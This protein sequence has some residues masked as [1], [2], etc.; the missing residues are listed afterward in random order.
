[1]ARSATARAPAKVN[2]A[3]SVGP[4]EP[5]GTPDA[6]MHPI[7]SWMAAIDLFDEVTLTE[8]DRATLD[9]RWAEDAPRPSPLGWLESDD[10]ALRALTLLAQH[11]GRE[12][13]AH[14]QLTK[15]I[16]VG[17]GLG[18]GSSDAAAC[19]T[20]ANTLFGLGLA[21]QDLA[22]LARRLG[23]DIPFFLDEAP[24]PRPALVTH[25]GERIRR[26]ALAP[27]ELV[28]IL[29]GFGCQTGAVYREY[30]ESPLTLDTARV[31]RLA[32]GGS[33]ESEELF[34]D[35][36]LPAQRHEPELQTLIARLGRVTGE[37]VHVSGSG[38]TL[39]VVSP[40]GS[41]LEAEIQRKVP[42][43]RC[44]RVRTLTGTESA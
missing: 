22:S 44:V 27:T 12:L 7:A 42:G 30:D 13:P 8:S 3:L 26:T 4:P 23:S 11:A 9:R 33:V 34:N 36:A 1:M 35:L 6:G 20:A 25:F 37:P 43:V 32:E 29:P 28:L 18:G 2:L 16:P 14:V 40:A 5:P 15:R 10:L 31:A 21:A 17:G 41:G 19:L 39:F 38:S 24:L